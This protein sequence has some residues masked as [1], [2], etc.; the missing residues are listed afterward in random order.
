MTEVDPDNDALLAQAATH[1][2]V[3]VELL[4]SL[5]ALERDFPDFSQFGSKAQF[6]RAVTAVLDA[7]VSKARAS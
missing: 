6:T 2:E 5:L 7:A 1:H 3:D 4:R